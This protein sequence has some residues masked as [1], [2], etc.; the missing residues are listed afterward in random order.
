MTRNHPEIPGACRTPKADQLL[1][2]YCQDLPD[3]MKDVYGWAYVNPRHVAWL[4]HNWVVRV[5]LFGHDRS[6]MRAYLDLVRPG[7]KVWQVAHVYGD[8]VCRVADKVGVNGV[9]DLTDITPVQVEHAR[10]KLSGV[11]QARVLHADAASHVG[12]GDYALIA[13]FFL[14]HE[15]PDEMKRR[16]VDNMLEQV[17]AHGRALFVDYH[18]P[19]WWHPVGLLLRVI[20]RRLEPFALSI[21]RHEISDYA[22]DAGAFEWRKRTLFGGVYQVLIAERK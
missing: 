12:A 8:L 7:M 22:R 19:A 3:Y 17:P 9:F 16:I 6:L 2:E 20:N 10:S 18:R 1:G 15:V 5:L 21:W 4:D 13:S 11:A 14:L